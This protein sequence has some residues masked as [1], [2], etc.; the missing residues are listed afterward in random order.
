MTGAAPRAL[1]AIAAFVE[2]VVAHLAA[3][4]IDAAAMPISHVCFRVTTLEE[5]H[6][7]LAALRP[8]CRAVAEGPFN[9]RPIS[10]L[11]LREPV[12]AGGQAV[13]LIELPAPR[14]AHVYPLGLEHVG[15]VT[16]GDTL[17]FHDRHAAALDGV[18]DRGLEV[19]VPFV[20]F[21]DGATAKFYA[22]PLREI[23]ERDGWRFAPV[24]APAP[25]ETAP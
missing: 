17:A 10:M 14:A 8:W 12:R 1:D 22:R 24:P 19:Q 23:V 5:Y 11:L 7:A 4:G 6:E 20:T 13:E 21:P 16:G 25:G 15:F 9:G 3:R 18:K 2:S